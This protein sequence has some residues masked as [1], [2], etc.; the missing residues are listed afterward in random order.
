M[1]KCK[2]FIL[3]HRASLIVV[4]SLFV[5][6]LALS[7]LFYLT[8]PMGDTVTVEVDGEVYLELLLSD[9]GEYEI[10]DTGNVVVIEGGEVYMKEAGCPDKT[11]VKV[12]RIS[13]SG[14]SIVCLP[15]R[16]TVTVGFSGDGIIESR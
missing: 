9:D 5:V 12:G 16:I 13:R 4:L 14:E 15:K 1:E 7:L 10:K 3:R 8:R 6:T 2:Q 11:C